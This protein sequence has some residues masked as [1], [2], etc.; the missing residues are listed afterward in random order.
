MYLAIVMDLH[1]RR[2]VGWAMSKSMTVDLTIRAFQMAVKLRQPTSDLLLHSDRGSQYTSDR[3]S[4]Y[5]S[6]RYQ[7]LLKRNKVF[8]SMSGRGA[9]LD[10]A[11]VE[12]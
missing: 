5:T 9:C 1:S 8:A 4:Q 7:V 2:I 11:V 6:K 3:G 12:R 10:N